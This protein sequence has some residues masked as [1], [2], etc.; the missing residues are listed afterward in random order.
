[1]E[2]V[3]CIIKKQNFSAA[4][5]FQYYLLAIVHSLVDF[6]FDPSPA[7]ISILSGLQQHDAIKSDDAFVDYILISIAQIIHK[8]SPFYLDICLHLVKVSK[9]DTKI[10]TFSINFTFIYLFSC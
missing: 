10:E 5:D 8:I 7:L 1:M 6:A 2:T 9:H 3:E 4:I